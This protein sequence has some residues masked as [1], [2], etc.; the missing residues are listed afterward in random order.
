[1]P[2]W[3]VPL[4]LAGTIALPGQ[5]PGR[6]GDFESA[7]RE[8]DVPRNVLMAL[9]YLESRWD[10]NAGLPSTAGGYGPMHLIGAA[11]EG[12]EEDRRGDTSRPMPAPL[13]PVAGATLRE[14][15]ALTGLPVSRLR[16]D[17]AANIRGGAAVLASYRGG[18]VWNVP[19]DWYEAVVRYGGSRAFADEVFSVMRSG[20]ERVTDDGHRVRLEPTHTVPPPPARD[21][22]R[23]APGQ[24]SGRGAG[25]ASGEASGQESGQGAGQAAAQASGRTPAQASAQAAGRAECPESLA[26]EWM[27][28]AYAKVGRHDYGNHDRVRGTARRVDYIVV[29]DTEGSYRGIPTMVRDPKYVSWHYSIR[30][31]DGHVAQHVP[32]SDIAWH[33]GN[34]DINSRAIGIEHEGFLAKGGT[35]YTE[36][37]YRS[38]ARLVRWLAAKYDV[39]LDRAHIIG[40]DNV[41]G[42]NAKTLRGMHEDPGPFWDWARYFA[43]MRAPFA[44]QPGTS[45]IIRPDF[46]TNHQTFT[47]CARK[48]PACAPQGSSTVWLRTAPRADAPLVGD[49]GKRNP[50]TYSVY[51]HSARASTGQRYAVAERSGDWTAIWYLGRKAWFHNPATRPTAIPASGALVTPLRDSIPVFGRAYPE[52]S[53]YAAKASYQKH[54]RLPYTLR[55]GQSYSLGQTLAGSYYAANSFDPRRHV[56]VRGKIR[57]HQI[58][59]GHRVMFVKA[60]DVR[61]ID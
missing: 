52:K 42:T 17:P 8:Y 51:D 59:L 19:I 40:H 45:V 16:D 12:H 37:M 13:T 50:G 48:K 4:V 15:A 24:G 7:A 23:A 43:L 26:C 11:P 25:Q 35:W 18:R 30:S 49:P 29:H 3:I 27:P 28:A 57:Y 2:L 55:S 20:A 14:A 38:S 1:M 5:Q 22:Q 44:A 9:S 34:W 33:A 6:Q 56:L 58:Q 36:A 61:V 32:T 46:A 41:P 39:P 31:H 21:P 10:G 47:G 53:A 54:L 60:R